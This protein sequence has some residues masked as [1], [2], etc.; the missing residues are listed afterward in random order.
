[1]DNISKNDDI[2]FE[3][4]RI[5]NSLEVIAASRMFAMPTPDI[6][7]IGLLTAAE[8]NNFKNRLPPYREN[9]WLDPKDKNP[10]EGIFVTA[11]NEVERTATNVNWIYVRPCIRIMN[12]SEFEYKQNVKVGKY[13]FVYMGEDILI[14]TTGIACV[15][16]GDLMKWPEWK[17]HNLVMGS[18]DWT[19]NHDAVV[20]TIDPG[21]IAG[22]T[23]LSEKEF[24]RLKFNIPVIEAEWWLRE[25]NTDQGP[26]CV[27]SGT[28]VKSCS[29]NTT[30][31]VGVRPA[32]IVNGAKC[33]LE[34]RDKVSINKVL[35]TDRKSVV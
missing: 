35:Y 31:K 14:C 17:W 23:L 9:W 6:R 4:K 5:A 26:A 29:N 24:T 25:N 12:G 1:M 8:F 30:L 11:F 22:I 13:A 21:N 19:E 27:Y 3:L 33:G 15:P 20:K 28:L 2:L 18:W 34:K 16:Y 7:N 10:S 32:F